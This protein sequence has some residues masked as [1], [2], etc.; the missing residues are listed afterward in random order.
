M[1]PLPKKPLSHTLLSE[2]PSDFMKKETQ[3]DSVKVETQKALRVRV[4]EL[5]GW[6]PFYMKGSWD[7]L[8]INPKSK[9][10]PQATWGWIAGKPSENAPISSAGI[11]PDYPNDLNACAELIKLLK[12]RGWTCVLENDLT[13]EWEC[14]FRKWHEGVGY[15]HEDSDDEL[16]TAICRAFIATME[17][18]E[19]VLLPR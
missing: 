13:G 8:L 19:T 18:L 17:A 3:S 10:Q 14:F 2:P 4:A 9:W 12:D 5:L 6:R 11:P 15:V 16:A 1:S 7:Y